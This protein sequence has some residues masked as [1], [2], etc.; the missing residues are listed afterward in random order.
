LHLSKYFPETVAT[1]AEVAKYTDVF[2]PSAVG[3]PVRK[4]TIFQIIL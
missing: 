2:A 3:I 4:S 1:S